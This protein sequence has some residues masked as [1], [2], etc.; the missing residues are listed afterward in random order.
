MEIIL[1]ENIEDVTLGTF[2]KYA[3]LLKREDLSE[4]EFNKRKI[5]IFTG[6]PQRKI[7]KVK[8]SDYKGILEQIDIALNTDSP[9]KNTFTLKDIT[10]GFNPNLDTM[11]TGEFADLSK[12]GTDI[13]NLHLVMAILYRPITEEVGKSYTIESYKGTKEHAETMREIP[14]NI[15][16]GVLGFFC[17]LAKG[18]RLHTQRFTREEL[19]RAAKHQTTSKNGI[20]MPPS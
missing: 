20:G 3:E 7:S 2:Q 17:S 11:T 19:L 13:E 4:L 8:Q 5:H 1:P 10:F 16:N 12:Y 18:L 6:I 14:L 9:F 15:A